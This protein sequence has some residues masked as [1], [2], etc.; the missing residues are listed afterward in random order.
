MTYTLANLTYELA[1]ELG[2][3]EEGEAT[4]GAV[5][6]LIDTNDRDEEE[7]YWVGGTIWLLNDEAGAGAAPEGEYSAIKAYSQSSQTI[8]FRDNMTV[9]PAAGDV[10]AIGKKRFPL[11]ILIQSVNRAIRDI[12]TIPVTDTSLTTAGSQTEYTLPTAANLD[13]RQ[14]FLQTNVDS[15]DNLWIELYDWNIERTATG[16]ADKLVFDSQPDYAYTLKLVYMDNHPKLHDFNDK[17][18]ETIHR[19]RIVYRSAAQAINWYRQKTR[20]NEKYLIDDIKYYRD[21][22][23]AMDLRYPIAAPRK[24]GKIMLATRDSRNYPGDRTPR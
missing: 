3:V 24:P 13:L 19:E 6:N 7:H 15:D 5:G 17:L 22:S 9:A 21:Y 2:V 23:A 8:T 11:S 1:I 16:S 12:G 14:V 18:S 10:Y 20:S 4:G